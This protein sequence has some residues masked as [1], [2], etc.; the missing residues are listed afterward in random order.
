MTF[1]ACCPPS[2]VV[3]ELGEKLESGSDSRFPC[4][5]VDGPAERW[6]SI[7]SGSAGL[8][9]QVLPKSGPGLCQRGL[10]EW[11]ARQ[12]QCLDCDQELGVSE[13]H[14]RGM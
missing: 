11:R 13:M 2:F 9:A 14:A 12:A 8:A 5:D 10:T 1:I 3:V 7:S 6:W 4:G